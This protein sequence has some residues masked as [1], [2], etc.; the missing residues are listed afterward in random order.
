MYSSCLSLVDK[1]DKNILGPNI[2]DPQLT[3]PKLFQTERTRPLACLPSFCELVHLVGLAACQYDKLWGLPRRVFTLFW[4]LFGDFCFTSVQLDRNVFSLQC[5]VHSCRPRNV[6][7]KQNKSN[8]SLPIVLQRLESHGNLMEIIMDFRFKFENGLNW[9]PTR[10]GKG[11]T[12][13]GNI[14]K[15][16]RKYLIYIKEIR[17]HKLRKCNCRLRK[18]SCHGVSEETA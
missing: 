10:G 11:M 9:D 1:I 13:R 3:R 4:A 7:S 6:L 16:S 15:V 18:F 2:F 8:R 5:C 14:L 12:H 17:G